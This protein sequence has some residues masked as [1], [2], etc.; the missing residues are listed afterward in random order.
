MSW[1]VGIILNE[2][3]KTPVAADA[4]SPAVLWHAGKVLKIPGLTVGLGEM[5]SPLAVSLGQALRF[6]GA[7]L[8]NF[9]V[10]SRDEFGVV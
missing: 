10:Q 4:G 3:I 9:L 6:S 1:R 7:W 2:E 5:L 8:A